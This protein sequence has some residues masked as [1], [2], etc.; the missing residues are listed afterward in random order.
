[1]MN[2]T[3]ALGWESDDLQLWLAG[4]CESQKI[5]ETFL[6]V[7]GAIFPGQRAPHFSGS[8]CSKRL[9]HS[10]LRLAIKI[11]DLRIEPDVHLYNEVTRQ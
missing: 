5:P 1:M 9:A 2:D 10:K 11:A 6:F 3:N 4:E 7:S 8:T